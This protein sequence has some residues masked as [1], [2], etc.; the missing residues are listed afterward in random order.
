ML[1]RRFVLLIIM[2][3]LFLGLQDPVEPVTDLERQG[4]KG[5]VKSV[6]ETRTNGEIS[7]GDARAGEVTYKKL[8]KYNPQGFEYETVIYNNNGNSSRVEYKFNSM[9]VPVGLNEY[10]DDGT[11]WLAVT[12]KLDDEFNKLKAVFEWPGKAGYDVIREKSEQLY[13]LL[14]RNPWG[15]IVYTNDFRGYPVEEEYLRDDSSVL[16]KFMYR[17]DLHGNMKEMTYINSKGRTSWE[18]KYKYNHQEQMVKSIVFKS[19]RVA[20]TSEYTFKYD[21][22]GNWVNRHEKRK[23]NYNI[24]TANMVE[25]EFYIRR[26][27]EYY[28]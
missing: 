18:T 6:L 4:L 12:Y 22:A 21:E 20:A 15:Y 19:N 28:P 17:Y 27:I 11:L 8:S 16:F 14:D 24:L 2:G 7:S 25:G 3:A 1:L 13:E 23:V 10:K 5:M 26:E 9:G